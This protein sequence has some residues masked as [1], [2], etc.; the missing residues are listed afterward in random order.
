MPE[1]RAVTTAVEQAF[2]RREGDGTCHVLAS[3][4][5][6]DEAAASWTELVE[7]LVGPAPAAV[8]QRSLSYRTFPDGFAAVLYRSWRPDRAGVDVHALLG[9]AEQLTPAVALLTSAWPG[10]RTEQP[11]DTRMERLRAD[12]LDVPGTAEQLRARVLADGDLLARS[13]AWL[14]QTPGSPLGLV[15]CPEE[16]RTAL[17]WGLLAVAAP[18]LTGRDWTFST[19]EQADSTEPPPGIAFLAAVPDDV[20]ARTVVDVRRFPAASPQNEYRANALVYRYEYGTEPPGFEAGGATVLPV[21]APAPVVARPGRRAPA[22]PSFDSMVAGVVDASDAHA[23]D[24]AL[25]DLEYATAALDDRA[26]LRATLERVGW[27]VPTVHRVIP[28]DER[29]TVV[30]RLVRV[31]FG[32]ALTGARRD[33]RRIV[34][35]SD[36]DDVVRALVQLDDGGALA[37]AVTRRWLRQHAPVRPDPAA[38]LSAAGRYLVRHGRLVVPRTE[39]IAL[40]VVALVVVVVCFLAGVLVGALG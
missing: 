21:P 13:L 19:H 3:S 30:D 12:E 20:G 24:S 9:L 15:G 7:P 5:A 16:Q 2:L 27:A 32:S 31:A 36:T 10:W 18:E 39:R 23:L 25:L 8:A 29:A 1:I 22:Q 35:N 28:F 17:V 6:D 26:E 33:A 38:G 11:A 37:Q 40:A 4:L 14:L 34:E